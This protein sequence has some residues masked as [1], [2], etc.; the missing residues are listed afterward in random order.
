MLFAER[1]D[2]LGSF[3]NVDDGPLVTALSHGTT[4]ERNTNPLRGVGQRNFGDSPADSFCNPATPTTSG[5]KL[6][7]GSSEFAFAFSATFTGARG[8][9]LLERSFS[10]RGHNVTPCSHF[11]FSVFCQCYLG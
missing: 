7:I 9:S 10:S 6:A 11:R 4:S 8:L 3:C 2:A 5:G 1:D